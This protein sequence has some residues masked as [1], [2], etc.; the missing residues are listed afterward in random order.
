MVQPRLGQRIT[1]LLRDLGGGEVV[2]GPHTLVRS[3]RVADHG[4]AKRHDGSGT[5]GLHGSPLRANWSA[6]MGAKA[7]PFGP[8]LSGACRQWPTA[9]LSRV[10]FSAP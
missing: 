3:G 8:V 1:V 5:D 6:I 4:S 10:S 7:S 2:E 9:A